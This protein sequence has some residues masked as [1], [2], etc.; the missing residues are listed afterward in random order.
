MCR[1]CIGIL[2]GSSGVLSVDARQSS[3]RDFVR[4]DVFACDIFDYQITPAIV[5]SKFRTILNFR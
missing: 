5:S 3:H 1:V 4:A 2:Y